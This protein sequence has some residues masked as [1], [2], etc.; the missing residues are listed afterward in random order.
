MLTF[1]T[2]RTFSTNNCAKS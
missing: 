2:V 1:E